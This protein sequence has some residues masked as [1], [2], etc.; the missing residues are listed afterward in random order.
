MAILE[1]TRYHVR[2]ARASGAFSISWTD[3]ARSNNC[4][5][6]LASS[7]NSFICSSR[8]HSDRIEST[9]SCNQRATAVRA[10]ACEGLAFSLTSSRGVGAL[11]THRKGA[12]A[13]WEMT[14]SCNGHNC[15]VRKRSLRRCHRWWHS[16]S[17]SVLRVQHRAHAAW[18]CHKCQP[19]SITS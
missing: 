12:S 3:G 17:A 11:S 7:H 13:C 1:T 6:A 9:P 10:R 8:I 18:F 16:L 2:L 15:R 19:L 4:S 14:S 5:A